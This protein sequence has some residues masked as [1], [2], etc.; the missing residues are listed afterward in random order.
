MFYYIRVHFHSL[1]MLYSAFRLITGIVAYTPPIWV[2]MFLYVCSGFIFVLSA[3]F[4]SFCWVSIFHYDTFFGNG[5]A[6]L[7]YCVFCIPDT[8][9]FYQRCVYSV[10][11]L[12]WHSDYFIAFA[13]SALVLCKL[14]SSLASLLFIDIHCVHFSVLNFNLQCIAM[15]WSALQCILHFVTLYCTYI[16]FTCFGITFQP[17]FGFSYCLF[18]FLSG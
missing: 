2:A 1:V 5:A 6:A 12:T 17:Q 3:C 7:F 18:L 4:S 15:Y 11:I 16:Y 14:S 9:G 8:L 13:E 10:W